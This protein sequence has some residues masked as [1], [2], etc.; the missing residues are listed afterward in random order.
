MLAGKI[1]LCMDKERLPQNILNC[2]P[3]WRR[4]RGRPKT[5]CKEG[6]QNDGRKWSARWGLGGQTSLQKK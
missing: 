4:K 1:N 6:T 5:R 2:I 3:T